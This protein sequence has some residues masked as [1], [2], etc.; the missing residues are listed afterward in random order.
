MAT[1]K[2]KPNRKPRIGD[3]YLY[4]QSDLI[5]RVIGTNDSRPYRVGIFIERRGG[6]GFIGNENHSVSL[7]WFDDLELLPNLKDYISQL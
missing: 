4:R 5:V 7:S 3:R 1:T 2:N 6:S